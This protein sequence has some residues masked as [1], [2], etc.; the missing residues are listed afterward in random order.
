MAQAARV[1]SV[2]DDGRVNQPGPAPASDASAP[3]ALGPRDDRLLTPIATFMGLGIAWLDSRPGYDATGVTVVLL[4]LGAM[5][6]AAASGRRPWLWAVQVGVWVPLF[7]IG[8]PTGAA[9]LAALVVT[10]SGAAIG[11]VIARIVA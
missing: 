4:L 3:R 7:E 11:Y 1:V 10:I 9:S 6:V 8:G 2:R 5:A